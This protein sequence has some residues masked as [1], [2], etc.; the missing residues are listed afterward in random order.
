MILPCGCERCAVAIAAAPKV[1]LQLQQLEERARLRF[2]RGCKGDAAKAAH[3]LTTS[4]LWRYEFGVDELREDPDG[5]AAQRASAVSR[6]YPAVLSDR[7]AREGRAL[8]IERTGLCDPAG[9]TSSERVFGDEDG[10]TAWLRC[11]VRLNEHAGA[12]HEQRVVIMDMHLA[13][14]SHLCK[15]GLDLI[16]RMIQIDQRNYPE[17]APASSWGFATFLTYACP[18]AGRCTASSSSTRRGCSSRGSMSSR[19]GWTRSRPPRFRSS[20][21]LTTTKCAQRYSMRS[22]RRIC[23]TSSA[24]SVEV[25]PAPCSTSCE[26]VSTPSTRRSKCIS[27]PA[28][29]PCAWHL[30][31]PQ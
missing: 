7:T 5:T 22:P 31:R 8:W 2:L 25:L 19:A 1:G 12:I 11:H 18:A 3:V 26:W 28:A 27:R 21:A 16:K 14:K 29:P 9:A 15:A 6:L 24:A 23:P 10:P 17:Y 13:N 4:Y 30:S 20:A